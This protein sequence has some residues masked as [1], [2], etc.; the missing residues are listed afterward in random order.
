M[1]RAIALT[2]LLAAP[3]A[4]DVPFER[5]VLPNGLVVVI[6]EDHTLPHVVVNLW[7]HVGSKDERPGHTGFAHLFEHLMFMGSKHVPYDLDKGA[8]LFD[9]IME[10][11]GGSNNATTT[12]DRT[13][14]FE[15]G[16]SQL[17]ETFL[18]LEADR[19][20]TL[21][22]TID[23][24]KVDRQRKIVQNERREDVDN[25]PY[26]T[27]EEAIGEEVFPEG[28]PYH[29]SVLGSHEDLERSTAADVRGFFD[30]FYVPANASLVVAGDLDTAAARRLVE[31]Y[32][33]WIQRPPPPPP[34]APASVGQAGPRTRT[35]TDRV[36]LARTYIV[37]HAPADFA[38]GS[39]ECEVLAR[40]LGGSKSSR[41]N[42]VLRLEKQIAASVSVYCETRKLAGL[43]NVVVTARPGHG[44][45][46]IERTVD[47]EIERLR[48]EPPAAVEVER[49]VAGIEMA[50][51]QGIEPLAD[52]ADEL[53]A[54]EEH[55]HDPGRFDWDLER[56]RKVTPAAVAALAQRILDPA[57]RVVLRVVPD[58]KEAP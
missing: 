20:A 34:P 57:D 26:G 52:R 10:E 7:Y 28:H 47:A 58:S 43:L 19:M 8:G 32:F 48:R 56:Y 53:N 4:A 33:G 23:Q 18:W 41:L 13:N 50:M 11:Q 5:T 14:F 37:Y 21:A 51:A 9:L 39:A 29:H 49:A 44:L 40:L 25:R 36:R 3:A 27:A 35:F 2:L 31:R 30:S 6:H 17:L 42:R 38:D 15:E 54:Y 1:R 12:N 45:D 16:P 22:Q 24:E 46:E 55:F